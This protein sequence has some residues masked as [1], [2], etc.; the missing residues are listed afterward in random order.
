MIN[1]RVIPKPWWQ[2]G[3]VLVPGSLF[4]LVSILNSPVLGLFSLLVNVLLLLG[5]FWIVIRGSSLANFPIWGIVPFGFLAFLVLG[6]LVS[7][8]VSWRTSLA[9]VLG[10]GLSFGLL[11]V[12]VLIIVKHQRFACMPAIIWG[13]IVLGSGI[14]LFQLAVSGT[15]ISFGFAQF[16][17]IMLL[18]IAAGLFLAKQHGLCAALLVLSVGVPL[19]DFNIEHQIYFWD[20]QFWNTA[21]SLSIP[22]L[23]YVIVPLWVLRSR[24][25]FAQ[26]AGILIPIIIYY[27]ALVSALSLKS[28]ISIARGH[29]F[30]KSISV[31]EPAMMLLVGMAFASGLYVWVSKQQIP[32]SNLQG[33][34]KI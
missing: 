31:A 19:M 29:A 2:V 5:V 11:C 25:V 23:F 6:P 34:N 1:R 9:H 22:L 28:A 27:V 13:I 30:M 18:L 33:S 26:A 3:L 21:F 20:H 32:R 12:S 4:F 14:T 8:I 24:S 10:L 16:W 15:L 7:F 17:T